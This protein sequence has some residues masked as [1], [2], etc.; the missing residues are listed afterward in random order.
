MI[1]TENCG[2]TE[3]VPEGRHR[4]LLLIDHH[5]WSLPNSVLE[6]RAVWS[7]L[8]R[9][10]RAA[11]QSA[12]RNDLL[13]ELLSLRLATFRTHWPEP[14]ESESGMARFVE[15]LSSM[16]RHDVPRIRAVLQD[17]SAAP[18]TRRRPRRSNTEREIVV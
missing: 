6:A 15:D 8:R 14:P 12:V 2:E 9:L 17:P 4:M 1:A 5:D 10:E 7:D 3:S 16:I 13:T 18:L 11:A